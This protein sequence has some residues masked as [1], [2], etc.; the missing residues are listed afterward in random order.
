MNHHVL[1]EAS[2]NSKPDFG[3]VNFT[4]LRVRQFIG[5]M[6]LLMYISNNNELLNLKINMNSVSVNMTHKQQH[7]W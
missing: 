1:L 7:I 2:S 5:D 3:S 4:W 6:E